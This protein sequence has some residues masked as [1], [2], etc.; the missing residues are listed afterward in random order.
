MT[1]DD[2]LGRP[3]DL[4]IIMDHLGRDTVQ[5]NRGLFAPWDY[6]PGLSRTGEERPVAG[7]RTDYRRKYAGP[8]A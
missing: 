5:F 8:L 2:E 7:K 1:A 6:G 3:A 4:A